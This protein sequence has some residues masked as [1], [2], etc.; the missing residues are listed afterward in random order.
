MIKGIYLDQNTKI[1]LGAAIFLKTEL[2]KIYLTT[3]ITHFYNYEKINSALFKK[4]IQYAKNILI[5]L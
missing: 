3:A 1:N 5:N 4:I 2:F